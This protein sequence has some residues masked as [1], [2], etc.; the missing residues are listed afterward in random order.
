MAKRGVHSNK[1]GF[2]AG[3][4]R[5]NPPETDSSRSPIGTKYP[6][7]EKGA[8]RTEVGQVVPSTLGPRT[9]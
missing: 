1:G 2:H 6:T 3:M 9:A 8:V 4:T 7:V 5:T